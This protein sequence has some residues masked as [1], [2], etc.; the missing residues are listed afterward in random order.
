MVKG[1]SAFSSKNIKKFAWQKIFFLCFGFVCC[2]TGYYYYFYPFSFFLCETHPFCFAIV[3]YSVF[4]IALKIANKVTV[5]A[6]IV[7]C[8]RIIINCH[9]K[10]S[11]FPFSNCQNFLFPNCQNFPLRTVKIFLFE[12]VKNFLFKLSYLIIA[13]QTKFSKIGTDHN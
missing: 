1:C 4:F 2:R 9:F 13:K 7:I 5:D 10:L 8:F 3:G 6:L 11:K 12:T